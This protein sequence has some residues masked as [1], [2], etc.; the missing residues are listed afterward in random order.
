MPEDIPVTPFD[1]G[2]VI[3]NQVVLESDYKWQAF[4]NLAENREIKRSLMN[5]W[6]LAFNCI[7]TSNIIMLNM[8][9]FMQ[10]MDKGNVA[11]EEVTS[12]AKP[13]W[14]GESPFGYEEIDSTAIG[15]WYDI[16]DGNVVSKNHVYVLNRGVTPVGK[17]IGN[18]KMM[19]LGADKSGF[20]IRIADLN[21]NNDRKIKINKKPELNYICLSLN[22]DEIKEIEPPSNDWDIVFTKYTYIFYEPEYIPYSVTGVLL[23]PKYTAIALDTVNSYQDITFDL[24]ENYQFSSKMDMIGY[25]WKDVN[26]ETGAYTVYPWMNYII[27]DRQGF[28][29]KLHFIDYYDDEGKKGAPKF[30]FQKL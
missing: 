5:E 18:K 25:D 19:I 10:I 2:D 23:N 11:F 27:R 12:A 21:G 7:D 26:I 22:K 28:Y 15:K 13:E 9:S 24:V 6:D 3:V 14:R 1:R 16:V 8:A 17:P 29:Y 20:E 30:E 4:F